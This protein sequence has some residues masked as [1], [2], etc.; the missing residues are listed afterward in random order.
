[1]P[2]AESRIR[3]LGL[4]VPDAP[5]PLAAYVP[6]VRTGD[7]VFVAGQLPF[8]DGKL[9]STGKVGAGVTIEQGQILARTA[10]LNALAVLRE[11]AG[12]LDAVARIVRVGVFVASDD[13]FT[14]QPKV[15]N[16]AS[17]LLVQVFGDA[18]RHARAAVGVN[19]LPLDAPVEVELIAE[20]RSSA[21]GPTTS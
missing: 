13:A 3:E 6:S 8:V 18:G 5:K 11:A 14:D 4:R 21:T 12:T 7:L 16:G 2:N 9:P 19:V 10:T 1:M 15:A 17:D 20:L